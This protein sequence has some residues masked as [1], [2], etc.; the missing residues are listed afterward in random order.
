MWNDQV[1]DL[2]GIGRTITLDWPGFG[3]SLSPLF[4]GF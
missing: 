3:G 2:A 1:S 4:P